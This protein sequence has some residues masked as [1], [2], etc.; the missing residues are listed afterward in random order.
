MMHSA[1]HE[2]QFE[3][4]QKLREMRGAVLSTR[5]YLNEI[6]T[7]ILAAETPV[8]SQFIRHGFSWASAYVETLAAMLEWA[9]LLD[10]E[11]RLLR[12]ELLI[13]LALFSEYL[14][15]LQH[16][17]AMSQDEI[18][19]P[20]HMGTGKVVEQFAADP[21]VMVFADYSI[22]NL[23]SDIVNECLER[24]VFGDNGLD[25]TQ[26]MI[27]AQ[28][29]DFVQNEVTP[30]AHVWHLEDR[31]IPDGVILKLADMGVF[32]LTISTK[33]GGTG[34]G[35]LAMCVVTEELSRGYMPDILFVRLAA[36][37]HPLRRWNAPQS[38][39][40]KSPTRHVNKGARLCASSRESQALEKRCSGSIWF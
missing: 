24:Q 11:N 25:D 39:C 27:A 2:I 38:D 17:I 14:A 33:Y 5:L 1:R 40:D 21:A 29:H 12:L 28:I 22:A 10:S 30:H 3:P 23:A 19:R 36:L 20:A 15:Q 8:E 18:I 9:E 6:R 34:L 13:A 26:N 16:G 35:K 32:G 7:C 4:V 31:L 37:M